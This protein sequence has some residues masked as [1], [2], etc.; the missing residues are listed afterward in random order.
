MDGG[1]NTYAY[2]NNNPTRYVDPTGRVAWEGSAFGVA[3][4]TAGVFTFNLKSKCVNGE[5][6]VATVLL[7]GPGFGFG[8][9]DFS[10]SSS[11]VELEDSL[12]FVDPM[13]FNDPSLD[14]GFIASFG[15]AMGPTAG[16]QLGQLLGGA[17]P[18]GVTGGFGCAAIRLGNAGGKGCGG[19][20]GFEIGI[21]AFV[22]SSTVISSGVESCTSC[23]Q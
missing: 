14:G 3:A 16:G 11:D 21:G 8:V 7:A 19:L 18:D 17:S 22:G 10:F 15:A 1:I 4:L 9:T 2:A 5:R 12:E 13:V 6:G 20:R 23:D